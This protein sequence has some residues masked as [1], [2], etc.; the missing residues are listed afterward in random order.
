MGCCSSR[1]APEEKQT[2]QTITVEDA[3]FHPE[4]SHESIK[5]EP[6]EEN[7]RITKNASYRGGNSSQQFN[8]FLL[9]FENIKITYKEINHEFCKKLS[10]SQITLHDK[11][12]ATTVSQDIPTV[13]QDLLFPQDTIPSEFQ[14]FLEQPDTVSFK[15]FLIITTELYFKERERLPQNCLEKIGDGLIVVKEMFDSIDEDGNGYIDQTEFKDALLPL[16]GG[17]NGNPALVETR[18]QELDYDHDHRITW[19]EFIFGIAHWIGFTED[20]ED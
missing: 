15:E 6:S 3:P 14:N 13:L 8:H 9:Q 7:I 11:M 18:M 1:S 5:E 10:T 19:H 2:G 17:K 12:R 4:T 16:S 20:D